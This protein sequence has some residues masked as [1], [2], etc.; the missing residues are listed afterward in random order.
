MSSTDLAIYSALALAAFFPAVRAAATRV[1]GFLP[2]LPARSGDQWSQ[3][4]S[5]SLIDLV[6]DLE[7]RGDHEAADLARRL[8]WSIIGGKQGN[9]K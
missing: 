2:G 5:C 9:A 8:I 6:S 1:W 4:W 7:S 3:R